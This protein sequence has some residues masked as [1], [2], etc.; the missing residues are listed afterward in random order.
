LIK[1]GIEDGFVPIFTTYHT[2]IF[3]RT[4]NLRQEMDVYILLLMDYIYT[5]T[6]SFIIY[7]SMQKTPE[8]YDIR[9]INKKI[10]AKKPS[11]KIIH[12]GQIWMYKV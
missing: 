3:L 6:I 7:I 8:L 9:N 2:L 1:E 10:L 11:D 5:M 12:V 4:K